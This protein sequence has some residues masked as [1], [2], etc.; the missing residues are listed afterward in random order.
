M[1]GG[2]SA[3]PPR[4]QRAAH[5]FVI[6]SNAFTLAGPM[7]NAFVVDLPTRDAVHVQ[8]AATGVKAG[9]VGALSPKPGLMLMMLMASMRVGMR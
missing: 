5:L 2:P 3:A 1:P 9:P 6:R 7:L 4:T 8:E